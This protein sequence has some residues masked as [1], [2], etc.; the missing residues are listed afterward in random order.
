MITQ[1]YQRSWSKLETSK[2]TLLRIHDISDELKSEIEYFG[3]PEKV[4]F[5]EQLDI[6]KYVES[7]Y[8]RIIDV[9][10]P[11][12]DYIVIVKLNLYGLDVAWF[13]YRPSKDICYQLKWTNDEEQ[14]DLGDFVIKQEMSE[15]FTAENHTFRCEPEVMH[16]II[17]QAIARAI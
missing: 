13:G 16:K 12:I 2:K 14:H 1:P 3:V 9:V 4:P 6:T 15:T 5:H 8:I 7:R 11:N 10:P 17:K